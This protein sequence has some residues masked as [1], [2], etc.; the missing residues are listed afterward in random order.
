MPLR[1]MVSLLLLV[2]APK[3]PLLMLLR[4]SSAQ[5]RPLGTRLLWRLVRHLGVL[6]QEAQEEFKVAA[7]GAGAGAGAVELVVVVRGIRLLWRARRILLLR[8]GSF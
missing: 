4:L 3:K 1:L 5:A 7:A 8:L 6:A 2:K